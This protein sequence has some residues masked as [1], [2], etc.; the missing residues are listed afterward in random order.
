[1]P[2]HQ[3]AN[4]CCTPGPCPAILMTAT[5]S[6][7]SEATERLTGRE[8]TP[9]RRP[10]NRGG[11]ESS[12]RPERAQVVAWFV[13]K[14]RCAAIK[15]HTRHDNGALV[16]CPAKGSGG[17]IK[18]SGLGTFEDA[19]DIHPTLAVR[20]RDASAVTH[21]PSCYGVLAKGP[22][23]G[24]SVARGQCNKLIAAGVEHHVSRAK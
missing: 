5:R 11:P 16:D 14:R 3:V 4:S 19:A 6:V 22:A 10:L 1:M 13:K 21:E 9:Y 2:G 24:N 7:P 12:V 18:R 20:V 8:I 17:R 23:C 15:A